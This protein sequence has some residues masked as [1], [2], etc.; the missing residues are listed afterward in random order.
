MPASPPPKTKP[1]KFRAA[2]GGAFWLLTSMFKVDP[3]PPPQTEDLS[4]SRDE[5]PGAPPPKPPMI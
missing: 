3:P 4:K 5:H 1:A 2:L